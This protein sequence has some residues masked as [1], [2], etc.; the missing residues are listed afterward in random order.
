MPPFSALSTI[1]PGGEDD[2]DKV[3]DS[4]VYHQEGSAAPTVLP[5]DTPQDTD[6]SGAKSPVLPPGSKA[7]PP[8]K[9]P[10]SIALN[11]QREIVDSKSSETPV[12]IGAAT[13]M[14]AQDLKSKKTIDR[15][16][17][18]LLSKATSAKLFYPKAAQDFYAARQI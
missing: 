15:P 8:I 1:P 3:L 10:N 16:L 17:M 12:P 2:T 18:R 9:D 5:Q 6:M 13:Q 4:Y 14:T 7:Q 11:M